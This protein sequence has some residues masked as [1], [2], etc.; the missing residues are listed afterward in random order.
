MGASYAFALHHFIDF[1]S[2]ACAFRRLCL[3]KYIKILNM[4]S[5]DKSSLQC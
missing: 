1:E 4:F 5:F 3:Y 2:D